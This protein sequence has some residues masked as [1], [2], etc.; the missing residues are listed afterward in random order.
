MEEKRN[1]ILVF[2]FEGTNVIGCF[3]LALLLL[4][5]PGHLFIPQGSVILAEDLLNCIKHAAI[6]GGIF[7]VFIG[8]PLL[9]LFVDAFVI[10][11]GVKLFQVSAASIV[12][13]PSAYPVIRTEVLREKPAVRAFHVTCGTLIAISNVTVIATLIYYVIRIVICFRLSM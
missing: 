5:N 10:M 7:L 1:P 8:I 13:A 9:L 12:G 6:A 11:K 3:G 4:I 2:I